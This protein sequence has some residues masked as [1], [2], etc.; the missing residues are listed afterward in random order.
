MTTGRLKHGNIAVLNVAME[1]PKHAQTSKPTSNDGTNCSSCSTSRS[2][3]SRSHHS[4]HAMSSRS[5]RP[6]ERIGANPGLDSQ[7]T[8]HMYLV[9]FTDGISMEQ[10][11]DTT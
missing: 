6:G 9:T 3:N 4:M 10:Q 11:F 5:L 2:S 1:R 7:N 8:D